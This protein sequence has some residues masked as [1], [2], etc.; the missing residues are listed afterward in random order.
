MVRGINVSCFAIVPSGIHLMVSESSSLSSLSSLSSSGAVRSRPFL[1]VGVLASF[2][3]SAGVW[4]G[5]LKSGGEEGE[6]ARRTAAVVGHVPWCIGGS[7]AC[8][9]CDMGSCGCI[10]R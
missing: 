2:L 6:V 9:R 8:G 3:S 5:Y 4:R 10:E 1:R 7:P